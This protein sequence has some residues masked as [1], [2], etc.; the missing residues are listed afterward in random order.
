MIKKIIHQ[1][2]LSDIGGVQRSFALYFLYASKKSNFHHSI[3]SMHNLIENFNDLKNYHNSI[4]N[5]LINKIKFLFF[6]FSDNYIIHFYNNL[7]S[8]SVKKILNVIPS[9]NIIFHERGTVWNA[10][11]EDFDI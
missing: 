9:S 7:G 3:Y 2:S 6:L 11:D 1:L 5:S 8:Y 4:H 10:K